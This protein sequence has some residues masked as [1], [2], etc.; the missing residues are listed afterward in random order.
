MVNTIFSLPRVEGDDGSARSD[1]ILSALHD[2][3]LD[4]KTERGPI[5]VLVVEHLENPTAN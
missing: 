5:Q 1:Y 3:N 4:M 2:L